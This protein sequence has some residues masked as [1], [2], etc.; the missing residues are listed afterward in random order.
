[1]KILIIPHSPEC[2]NLHNRTHEIGVA[3]VS[4]GYEVDF[5]KWKTLLGGSRLN[6]VLTQISNLFTINKLRSVEGVSYIS[7]PMLNFPK[8]NWF[9]LWFNAL[10]INIYLRINPV[11]IVFCANIN[12]FS[13][14]NIN[15]NITIFDVVDDH[16]EMHKQLS[17]TRKT[18]L[19][20]ESNVIN[21]T[22]VTSITESLSEKAIL[23]RGDDKVYVIGNGFHPRSFV[24]DDYA[25]A[26]DLFSKFELG[27]CTVFGY[28]GGIDHWVGLERALD[29]F[30][31]VHNSYLNSKFLIVGGSV[32]S[33][34]YENIKKRYSS[35]SIIFTG[36]VSREIVGSYFSLLTVGIIPFYLMNFTHNAFPIK[37][38]EYGFS[39]ACIL[40]SRLRFLECIN[41]DF[42]NF[43]DSGEDLYELML[44]KCSLEAHPNLPTLCT[45][46]RFSESRRRMFLEEY[47][48]KSQ[49]QKLCLVF[50]RAVTQ[51]KIE[52]SM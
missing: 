26:F 42:V 19:L 50:D 21:S 11:D 23:M 22:I 36:P 38:I 4:L 15:A 16:F 7:L 45:F 29:A 51:V 30:E 6:K 2:E 27:G 14:K 35:D 10:I 8:A 48:W 47:S 1:M 49:A 41:F 39:G 32:D 17:L 18:I 25:L 43:F 37:A 40:S 28:I 33:Y 34:Y 52:A 5:L 44:N 31:R 12:Y 20:H 24:A 13:I 9:T 3:L 46:R